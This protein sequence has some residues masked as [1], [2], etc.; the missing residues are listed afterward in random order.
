ML[1][2]LQLPH[3]PPLRLGRHI[4]RIVNALALIE[5]D[6][7]GAVAGGN[8]H[9]VAGVDEGL[10]RGAAGPSL[11]WFLFWCGWPSG[12]VDVDV[13]LDPLALQEQTS[14]LADRGDD[15]GGGADDGV[16]AGGGQLARTAG[17]LCSGRRGAGGT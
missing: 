7:T 14:A 12:D 13:V 15:L 16:D 11:A 3:G 1:T 2:I 6:K 5:S 10:E 17:G 8:D 9:W 4:H